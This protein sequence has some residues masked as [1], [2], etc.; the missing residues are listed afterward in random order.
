[1]RQRTTF[2]VPE[3]YSSVFIPYLYLK[4]ESVQ[5]EEH[6]HEKNVYK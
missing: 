2:Y 3:D 4:D 6:F 5:V 1:M